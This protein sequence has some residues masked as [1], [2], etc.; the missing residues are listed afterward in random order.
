M[1]PGTPDREVKGQES[2][3]RAFEIA[4][5]W[6]HNLFMVEPNKVGGNSCH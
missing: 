1:L 2:S 5:A 3:K 4:G 6:G